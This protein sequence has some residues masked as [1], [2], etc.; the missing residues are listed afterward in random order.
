[1]SFLQPILELGDL[2]RDLIAAR[3][4]L[5]QAHRL[6]APQQERVQEAKDALARISDETKSGKRDVT[7]L[8]GEASAKK[9]A[10]LKAQTA[11][12]TAK[13]NDEYQ[14]HLRTIEKAKEDLSEIETQ[15]L[16][17]YEAQDAREAEE[18]RYADRLKTQEV[19]LKAAMKL[20]DEERARCQVVID[21]LETKRNAI[22]EG[23]G[24][25]HRT[26]YEKIL[27]KQGDTATAEVTDEM[28]QG[29]YM[30]IRPD[31]LSKLR[32]GKE[33]LTCFTCG[34]I[35]YVQPA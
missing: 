35:L 30:R 3:R 19:E 16:E 27:E 22:R 20:V 24:A 33:L 21:E 23:I 17:A 12:N 10:I 1:V 25:E 28:C 14:G 7:R 29:C 11:L 5:D 6:A 2:D 34:R 26:L 15:I 18:K 31:Q 13:S 9:D 4:K 8:E 32:G